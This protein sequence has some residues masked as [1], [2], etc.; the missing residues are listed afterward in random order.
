MG[1][2]PRNLAHNVEFFDF[3][4][5]RRGRLCLIGLFLLLL[6]LFLLSSSSQLPTDNEVAI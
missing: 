4:V 3:T 5:D 6:L 1:I 2:N